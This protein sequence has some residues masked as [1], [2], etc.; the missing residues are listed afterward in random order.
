MVPL[1]SVPSEIVHAVIPGTDAT[2][3]GAGP[4]D[5]TWTPGPRDTIDGPTE[6]TRWPAP[7][8]QS[9][10]S[11]IWGDTPR[12]V[13]GTMEGPYGAMVWAPTPSRENP[14]VCHRCS[15]PES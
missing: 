6:A 10:K 9:C 1:T 15:A 3:P 2:H 5:A 13:S 7:S 11:A 4:E 8:F 14:V 12:I